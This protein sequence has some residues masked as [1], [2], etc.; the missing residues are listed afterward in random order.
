MLVLLALTGCDLFASG[1]EQID[2]LQDTLDGLTNPLVVQGLILG[3]A[4][5]DSEEIDLSQTDF[6]KGTAV[7][8]FAADAAS[9]NEIENAP[10]TGASISV[11]IGEQAAVDLEEAGGGA[12]K[13][14]GEEVG[15]NA[16]AMAELSVGIGDS[17]AGAQV[18]L[19]PPANATLPEQ[20]DGSELVIDL[21]SQEFDQILVVVFDAGSGE[22][23]FSNEP[24][25]VMELYEFSTADDAGAGVTI[26]ASAFPGESVYAVGIA[27][28]VKGDSDNFSS[29]NTA[30]SSIQAGQIKFYPVSTLALP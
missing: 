20:H 22:V 24:K 10:V 5:P 3:V 17:A 29:M 12:Y 11:K 16:S 19:P 2:D 30:L 4:E 18:M 28:L 8:V 14:A 23:T 13:V 9:V 27:G 1:Q 7:T 15:Y 26:P 21:S 6:S 25:D